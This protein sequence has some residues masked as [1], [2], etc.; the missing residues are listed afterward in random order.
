MTGCI[1]RPVKGAAIHKMGILSISA[2]SVWKIRLTFAFCKPKANWIPKNPT[3][4]LIICIRLS[5]GF[6][7]G[8][9][10]DIAIVFSKRQ[11]EGSN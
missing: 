7:P 4:I 9:A 6:I 1:T 11:G 8:I 2:P 5:L 3:L 10:N